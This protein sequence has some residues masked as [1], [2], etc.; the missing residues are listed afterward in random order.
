MNGFDYT[1]WRNCDDVDG[2]KSDVCDSSDVDDLNPI[3]NDFFL[4]I[5]QVY[6]N[7]LLLPLFLTKCDEQSARWGC[8]MINHH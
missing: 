2:E 3:G 8:L 1:I 5:P 4:S 6:Q 7:A